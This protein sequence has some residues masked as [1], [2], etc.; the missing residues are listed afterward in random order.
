VPRI[1]SIKP[2]FWT[3]AQVMEC[4]P[5]AR[6][7]FIGLWNF[8][9][10]HGRHP[11]S[12]K[13]LKAE[14]FPGDEFTLECIRGMVAELASNGL[15][16]RYTVDGKGF[17][18]VTGWHHQR[19]DKRQKPKY[20][21]PDDANAKPFVDDS[22]NDPGTFPPDRIGKDRIG[23]DQRE[24]A[25]A[26]AAL[27]PEKS[28]GSPIPIPSKTPPDDYEPP[29]LL[30][31]QLVAARSDLDYEH[32]LT[33]FRLTEYQYP[34]TD[35]DR[36]FAKFWHTQQARKPARAESPDDV[37]AGLDELAAE[38]RSRGEYGGSDGF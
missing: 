36:A 9:D 14:I 26:R 2:E 24:S 27:S 5:N 20:P 17:L 34:R 7:L 6:L 21:G 13:Q 35:W 30:R 18:T 19:I 37:F 33:A 31:R 15:V 4:S 16:I 10:D 3:S 32:T 12:A 23:E 8:C 11:D 25:R 22:K 29:E 38:M 28:S 1:R